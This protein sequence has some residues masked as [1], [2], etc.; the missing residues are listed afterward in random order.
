MERKGLMGPG[1]VERW[2]S[3]RRPRW[4]RPWA[5]GDGP[6]GAG[7]GRVP[8]RAGGPVRRHEEREAAGPELGD[9]GV[10]AD[11]GR[12]LVAAAGLGAGE[13]DSPRGP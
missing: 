12:S 3:Q 10:S 2:A 13:E 8:S 9:K 6:R 11:K 4:R 5:D 1:D 7:R